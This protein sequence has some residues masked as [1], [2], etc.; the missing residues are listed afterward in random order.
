MHCEQFRELISAY[1]ERSIAPPLAAKMDEHAAVCEACR[2]ELEDV[3]RLWQM[4]AEAKHVEPPASLHARIMQEVYANVPAAPALRWWELAWRPRFAFAAAAVLVVLALVMWS[5]NTQTD[6]IALS[7]VSGG[8]SPVIPMATDTLPVR[9]E[10]FLTDGGELR[11]M[12]RLNAPGPTKVEVTAGTQSVWSG[13][14]MRETTAILPAMAQG[15][16]LEVRVVWD[17]SNTL[18]AWLPAE[19][20]QEQRK[21]ALVLRGRSIEET[22]AHIAQAYSVPLVLVGGTDPLTRVSVES[23]GVTLD[24]LLRKLAQKLNLQISRAEDG[25]TVL[26]A[27]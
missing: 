16:V 9:F 13:V 11:W 17:S 4:M 5:R 19:I 6:A 8:G 2:T 12:L 3:Q 21:P 7:V 27:R 22:L 24:E 15:T 10:P 18:R 14:V 1:I 23:S 25:T 20:S 26:T